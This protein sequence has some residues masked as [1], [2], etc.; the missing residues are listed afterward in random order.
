MKPSKSLREDENVTAAEIQDNGEMIKNITYLIF[1]YNK[2]LRIT[3][4]AEID[5]A[6]RGMH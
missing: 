1:L 2:K 4:K 3:N 6:L 5:I